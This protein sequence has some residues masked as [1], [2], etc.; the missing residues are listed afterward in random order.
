MEGLSP[1]YVTLSFKK[2][3]LDYDGYEDVLAKVEQLHKKF[4]VIVR[5]E[6]DLDTINLLKDPKRYHLNRKKAIQILKESG[7]KIG[8]SVNVRFNNKKHTLKDIE[9]ALTKL[10]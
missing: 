3:N 8:A 10:S 2:L 4:D 6:G 7:R 1:A 5:P 9:S